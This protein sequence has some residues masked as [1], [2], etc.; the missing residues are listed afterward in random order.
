MHVSDAAE[1][2]NA[3]VGAQQAGIASGTIDVC[4]QGPVSVAVLAEQM[5]ALTGREVL[6]AETAQSEG[7]TVRAGD[8]DQLARLVGWRACKSTER[9]LRDAWEFQSVGP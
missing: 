9:I 3:L 2:L 8:P 5:R 7:C 1:G 4:A 6:V